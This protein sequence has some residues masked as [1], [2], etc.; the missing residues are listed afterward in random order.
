M[1]PTA[2]FPTTV[3]IVLFMIV[4]LAY[5][6]ISNIIIKQKEWLSATLLYDLPSVLR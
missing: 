3:M 2:S 4:E 6:K 1:I 5:A